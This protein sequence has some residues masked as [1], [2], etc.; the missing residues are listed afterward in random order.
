M[1][2]MSSVT[3][4]SWVLAELASQAVNTASAQF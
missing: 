2:A 4:L 3:V 1:I